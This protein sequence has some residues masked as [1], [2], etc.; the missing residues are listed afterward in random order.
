MI[1]VVSYVQQSCFNCRVAYAFLMQLN[2]KKVASR[3]SS[4]ELTKS[5][6]CTHFHIC[7]IQIFF[8]QLKGY[9]EQKNYLVILYVKIAIS[10]KWALVSA[11]KAS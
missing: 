6:F 5:L 8:V 3:K 4:V 1:S 2:L 7:K 9:F 10:R 11:C